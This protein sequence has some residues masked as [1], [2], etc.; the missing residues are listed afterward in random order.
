MK[1]YLNICIS[2]EVPNE[3]IL[4]TKLKSVPRQERLKFQKT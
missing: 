4:K 2:E 3:N 1:S